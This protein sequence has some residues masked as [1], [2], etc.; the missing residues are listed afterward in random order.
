MSIASI[1]SDIFSLIFNPKQF[2]GS[3]RTTNQI[4]AS[5]LEAYELKF[6][7]IIALL[8]YVFSED[9]NYFSKKEQ[10]KVRK[11]LNSTKRFVS[12]E[13]R[14]DLYRMSKERVY[15]FQLL[16]LI[17]D[18]NIQPRDIKDAVKII[19]MKVPNNNENGKYFDI[20]LEVEKDLLAVYN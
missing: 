19:Q 11:V 20:L 3:A 8:I 15:Y 5:E 1:I 18:Y 14:I 2:L 4:Y 10:H 13:S 16:K 9:D 6:Y 17:E 7:M 12:K